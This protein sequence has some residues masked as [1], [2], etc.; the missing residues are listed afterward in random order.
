[1]KQVAAYW[2][3]DALAING[4]ILLHLL[5]ALCIGSILG[6]ERSFH[7][8]AA[9]LRTY[10]VV[11]SSSTLLI[12]VCGFPSHWF[13]GQAATMTL[14]ADPTRVIQGIVTGIGFVGA[15]VIMRDGFTIR[16]LSTAASVWMTAAIGIAIG[17]GF[18]IAALAAT[19]LTMVIMA[20]F[21]RLETALPHRQI[22]RLNLVYVRQKARSL[23]EV[24]ALLERFGFQISDLA[25][26][27]D[28]DGNRFEYMAVLQNNGSGRFEALVET[29]TKADDV[30]SFHLAPSR[31]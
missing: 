1:M 24:C 21:R 10:A 15:G 27:L 23:P 25:C 26:Q 29:L 28:R 5:A 2:S 7:G 3:S 12:I 20:S 13:G 11:C 31:D 22:L 8:R 18:F 19:L 30:I 9:G 17:L 14:A 6:Y 4:I 16:G